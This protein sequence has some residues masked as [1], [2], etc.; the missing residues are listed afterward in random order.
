L[1]DECVHYRKVLWTAE[2]ALERFTLEKELAT[3]RDRKR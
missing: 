1:I 3:G 2:E